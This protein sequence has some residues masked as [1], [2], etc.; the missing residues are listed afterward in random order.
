MLKDLGHPN[1]TISYARVPLS[2]FTSPPH[3]PREERIK[4]S[5]GGWIVMRSEFEGLADGVAILQPV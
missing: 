1:E 3:T 2:V 5:D 4:L